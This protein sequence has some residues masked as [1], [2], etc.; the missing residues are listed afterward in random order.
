MAGSQRTI[1]QKSERRKIQL[2]SLLDRGATVL[3]PGCSPWQGT[4]RVGSAR[5]SFRS[6]TRTGRGGEP[7]HRNISDRTTR[8]D[9]SCPTSNLTSWGPNPKYLTCY[10]LY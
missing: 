4:A 2:S 5:N 8:I 9:S 6:R 7:R 3:P 1:E 10:R